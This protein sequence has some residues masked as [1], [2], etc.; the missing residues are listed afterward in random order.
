MPARV[1]RTYLRDLGFSDSTILT[2]RTGLYFLGLVD[3]QDEPTERLRSMVSVEDGSANRALKQMIEEVYQPALAGLNLETSTIG[4][5]QE[6]FARWG[7]D[8]NVGHKCVSF[9][10]ALAKDAGIPLSPYLLKRS[11]IGA[12]QRANLPSATIPVRRR[13]SAAPTARS[14]SAG[15]GATA[16]NPLTTK[17]PDFDPQWPKEVRDQWFEHA[18]ALQTMLAVM[19]KMP[20]FNPDWPADVQSRWFECMRDLIAKTSPSASRIRT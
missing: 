15:Y 2:I 1:D 3:D 17:L 20:S 7:A 11:R 14:A 5:L 10:L 4:L 6:R 19:G 16:T 9:F 13:R 8:N 18:Q 12:T